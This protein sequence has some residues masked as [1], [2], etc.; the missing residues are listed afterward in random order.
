MG[1]DFVSVGML[2]SS[3]N[4]SSEKISKT[5]KEVAPNEMYE[6]KVEVRYFFQR[7]SVEKVVQL[8]PPTVW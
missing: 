3:W 7:G 1:V 5:V 8:I 6:N 4:S 2:A